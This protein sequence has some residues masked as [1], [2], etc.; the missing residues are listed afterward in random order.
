L[1]R[2]RF[3]NVRGNLGQTGKET[4]AGTIVKKRLL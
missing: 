2:S 4:D 1:D 3:E